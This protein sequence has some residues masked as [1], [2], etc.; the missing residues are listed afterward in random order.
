MIDSISVVPLA[1]DEGFTSSLYLVAIRWG[2]V[3]TP[4]LAN[5][6]PDK[7]VLKMLPQWSVGEQLTSAM[8]Q[9]HTKEAWVIKNWQAM[10]C[11]VPRGFYTATRPIAGDFIHVM[12]YM[13][14][15]TAGDQLA[16]L[17]V[18]QA[19]AAVVEIAK[20]HAKFWGSHEPWEHRTR[21]GSYD[22]NER[23]RRP[24]PL[25]A[26]AC[27]RWCFG[28]DSGSDS[29][30]NKLREAWRREPGG[31]EAGLGPPGGWQDRFEGLANNKRVLAALAKKKGLKAVTTLEGLTVEMLPVLEH[32]LAPP[33]TLI[34]GDLRS[35]N[36]MF[37]R[38]S[39]PRTPDATGTNVRPC[40]I[41]WGGLQRGKGV[42]DVAY[43][44]G[45][46]MSHSERQL[47]QERVLQEYHQALGEGG[48][49]LVRY[50]WEKLIVD[51][52]AALFLS[53][54]L[55]AMP[56]VYDRGT[57]TEENA[58]AAKDV[59]L[60]LGAEP[61][62]HLLEVVLNLIVESVLFVRRPESTASIGR[63]WRAQLGRTSAAA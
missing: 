55:Y 21:T 18:D 6:M 44:L 3:R 40:I 22:C 53:S 60:A 2:A 25:G 45:T 26:L 14:D 52:E 30:D 49:D 48:V 59:G 23:Q 42:F 7:V 4:A 13:A 62:R 61:R 10:G 8:Q 46:G 51:Y 57:T 34:H 58:E 63:A 11:R 29:H 32:L 43:L 9:Q 1:T 33:Q 28:G 56:G 35:A 15:T 12:E 47:H 19:V 24:V 31:V 16:S 38:Q 39:H 5:S 50:S 20:M 54:V 17:P 41:D 27:D 37:P 36:V